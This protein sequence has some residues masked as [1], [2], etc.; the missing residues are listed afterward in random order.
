MPEWVCQ[1]CGHRDTGDSQLHEA[2]QIIAHYD[3]EHGTWP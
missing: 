3:A 1:L 2:M